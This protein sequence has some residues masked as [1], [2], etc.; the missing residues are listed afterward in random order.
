MLLEKSVHILE[1]ATAL[2]GFEIGNLGFDES[3]VA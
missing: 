3:Q 2:V 1:L